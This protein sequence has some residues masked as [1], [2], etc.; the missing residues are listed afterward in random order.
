MNHDSR[1]ITLVS[2][3][4]QETPRKWYDSAESA[5]RIVIVDSFTRLRRAMARPLVDLD[6]DVERVILD[7]SVSASE[8]LSLLAQLPHEFTGDLLMIRKDE[9]GFLSANGRGGDRVLY[10]LSAP[11]LGFYLE[12]HR[13]ASAASVQVPAPMRSTVLQF[14]ARSVA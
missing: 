7:R 3:T 13:L 8:Y 5:S 12:T 4:A 2:Q 10:A 6:A 1:R 14:R 11:D 9:T